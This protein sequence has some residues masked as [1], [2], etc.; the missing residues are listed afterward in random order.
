MLIRN[1]VFSPQFSFRWWGPLFLINLFWTT[2]FNFRF[3]QELKKD[4]I[5]ELGLPA[6]CLR[7]WI[8][9]RPLCSAECSCSY[10]RIQCV[11]ILLKTRHSVSLSKDLLLHEG[12]TAANSLLINMSYKGMDNYFFS[13]WQDEGINRGVLQEF[14]ILKHFL[15]S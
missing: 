11:Q 14:C 10:F 4:C 12:E 2:Y 3:S 13:G 15:R 5:P 7:L 9:Q 1:C 8:F 6:V